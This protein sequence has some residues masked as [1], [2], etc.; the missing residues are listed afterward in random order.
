[1]TKNGS[2][3]AVLAA[4]LAL[5]ALFPGAAAAQDR[6]GPIEI[7]VWNIRKGIGHIR[8]DI[9]TKATFVH[10]HLNCPYHGAAPAQAGMTAVMV[11][12]VPQG[13]FAAQVFQDEQDIG[14]VP[15]SVIGIPLVGVGFSNDAPAP[16]RPPRFADARFTHDPDA[17]LTLR[18]K[19]RY[20]PAL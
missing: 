20:Y 14:R 9:C 10:A 6:R 17:P 19:L 12:D 1:M 3:A 18:I 11:P 7:V 2:I 4:S 15:R 5:S 16:L 8:V 13:D